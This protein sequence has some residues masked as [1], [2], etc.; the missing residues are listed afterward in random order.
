[1]KT[2]KCYCV[3]PAVTVL[4]ILLIV[5]F[6]M[7]P[8]AAAVEQASLSSEGLTI[9]IEHE[10]SH[11]QITAS[12]GTQ[13]AY[14]CDGNTCASIIGNGTDQDAIEGTSFASFG[15]DSCF[16]T[17]MEVLVN[18]NPLTFSSWTQICPGQDVRAAKSL[19]SFDFECGDVVSARFVGLPGEPSF[20][21]C[22]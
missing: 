10:S 22:G 4:A 3:G 1:M 5:A 2:V 12:E 16:E 6:M 13:S 11:E 21:I 8:P 15:E 9:D 19:H 17:R 18:D 20:G 7:T 14:K